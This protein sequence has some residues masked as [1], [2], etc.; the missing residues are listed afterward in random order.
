MP[1]WL[2]PGNPQTALLAVVLGV[3]AVKQA[4]QKGPEAGR[5]VFAIVAG[6]VAAMLLFVLI[7]GV[8]HP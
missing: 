3:L 7:N 5:L 8:P 6:I 4:Y 2:Q 1:P